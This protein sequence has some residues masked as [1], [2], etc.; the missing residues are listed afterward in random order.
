ME[1]RNHPLHSSNF[2]P[3]E[4]LKDKANSSA[5]NSQETENLKYSFK[6]TN[7][8]KISKNESLEQSSRSDK[9][10]SEGEFSVADSS[11]GGIVFNEEGND[12]LT[13]LQIKAYGKDD[14]SAKESELMQMRLVAI[15]LEKR[16]KRIKKAL[17]NKKYLDI[18][19]LW[20]PGEEKIYKEMD[21]KTMIKNIQLAEGK[22]YKLIEKYE[23]SYRKA[24]QQIKDQKVN[25][26]PLDPTLKIYRLLSLGKIELAQRVLSGQGGTYFS[27]ELVISPA[28]ECVFEV[29]NYKG[30]ADILPLNWVVDDSIPPYE[31]ALR[32]AAAYE[33]S[34]AFGFLQITPPTVIAVLDCPPDFEKNKFGFH[35]F[36]NYLDPLKNKEICDACVPSYKRLCAVQEKIEEAINLFDYLKNWEKE[37]KTKNPNT[38]ITDEMSKKMLREN[39][40]SHDFML[41]STWLIVTG[42]QDGNLGNTLVVKNKSKPINPKIPQKPLRLIQIDE[43]LTLPKLNGNFRN[44]LID[45]FPQADEPLELSI[46]LIIG[47]I[48][49]EKSNPIHIKYGLEASTDATK[50]RLLTLKALIEEFPLISIRELHYRL[51]KMSPT[52]I[53]F[54]QQE[55]DVFADLTQYELEE[56]EIIKPSP[57]CEKRAQFNEVKSTFSNLEEK[58]K[59]IVTKGQN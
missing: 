56:N 59:A 15:Q 28:G 57:R 2:L 55:N 4:S 37:M 5:D 8:T 25:K 11:S 13:E 40:S 38:K 18:S 10:D 31:D 14:P 3:L 32:K 48:D 49:P 46:K 23:P 27:E 16:E 9:S 53:T 22:I 21:P 1:I 58:K 33:F 30:Y 29:H 17:E 47:D 44:E 20:V 34:R 19:D 51:S 12:G 43:G 24:L 35:Y 41:I 54:T 39:F 7:I 26:S 50:V 42:N 36:T 52:E 45:Y 6:V